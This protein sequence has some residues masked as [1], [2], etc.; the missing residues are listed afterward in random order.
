ML[1]EKLVA[2]QLTLQS[3]DTTELEK[4]NA[5]AELKELQKKLALLGVEKSAPEV[6]DSESKRPKRTAAES[7][8]GWVSG[9]ESS[10]LDDDDDDDNDSDDGS[11]EY[12]DDDLEDYD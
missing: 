11:E 4:N 5:R 6:P 10:G 8:Q 1:T 3:R 7:G 9:D 12:D 2:K